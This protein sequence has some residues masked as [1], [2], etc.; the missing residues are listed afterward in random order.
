MDFK[1]FL[2][3]KTKNFDKKTPLIVDIPLDDASDYYR[4]HSA[5][6]YR[7]DEDEDEDGHDDD[8]DA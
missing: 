8:D 7:D 5:Y 4:T 3:R 2:K 6:L 1:K